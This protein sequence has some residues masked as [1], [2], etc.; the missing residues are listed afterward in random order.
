MVKV[1]IN[2][3][4][5]SMG[6]TALLRMDIEKQIICKSNLLEIPIEWIES[7][8]ERLFSYLIN[9]YSMGNKREEQLKRSLQKLSSSIEDADVKKKEIYTFNSDIIKSTAKE[10]LDRVV[11][12]FPD[13]KD[14]VTELV[15]NIN[16]ALK[17]VALDKLESY[18]SRTIDLLKQPE[19]DQKLTLNVVKATLLANSGGQVSFLNV[20]KN[21]LSYKEQIALFRKDFIDPLVFELKMQQC[22]QN[23]DT[24]QA[25]KLIQESECDLAVEWKKKNKKATTMDFSYFYEL[26]NCSGIEGQWGTLTYE[27]MMFM[28][29]AS[30]SANDFYNG[31]RK[32]APVI[33]KLA[34]ILLFIAPIGCVSYKKMIGREEQFVYGFL[35]VEG[36]CLET[37][38]RNDIFLQSFNRDK[39]FS[40]ALVSSHE[41]L[42]H[43]EN[44]RTNLTVLIEWITY[45]QAKK[46][47][48]EY[49]VVN[50]VFIKTL[51]EHPKRFDLNKI[52]PVTFREQL[53]HQSLRNND[54]KTLIFEELRRNITE[55]SK[56]YISIKM[57]LVLRELISK[58]GEMMEQKTLTDRMYGRGQSINK[59][60][61]QKKS[62]GDDYRAP[63]EKK[64]ATISYRL[65]NA[66]K[67]GNRQVFFDTVL[68]LHLS[69]SK[70]ISKEFASLLDREAVSDHEF[71]TMSLAFIAGLM[72]QYEVKEKTEEV[73]S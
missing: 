53:V 7:L 49:R 69:A 28:P 58:G 17:E 68:R 48:L 41:K 32:N 66:A 27:E 35:H 15:L 3:W 37:K 26:P 20:T 72:S 25:W 38:R 9:T 59:Y 30:N 23:Q 61:T 22:I 67:G 33:S 64:L 70:P 40:K 1:L 11:K 34:R 31:Q 14:E 36:D 6:A 44:E 13:Y 5:F 16:T 42:V 47:L 54:T 21:A 45:S 18:I 50:E 12:Y 10:G 29:L 56:I 55:N 60:F 43:V 52:F 71:A 62:E 51:V 39:L 24:E 19:I 8:P 63:N 65:L 57:A 2:D 73:K 46:T 4:P